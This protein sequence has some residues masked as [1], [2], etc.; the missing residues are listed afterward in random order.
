MTN[1]PH[2][3]MPP[4]LPSRT[5]LLVSLGINIFLVAFIL[6]RLTGPVMP[7]PPMPFGGADMPSV[8]AAA[9][10][11]GDE[12]PCHSKKAFY[13]KKDG[14]L[15][16]LFSEAE[17]NTHSEAARTKFDQIKKAKQDFAARL[18]EGPVSEEEAMAFFTAMGGHF[19]RMKA[20]M[21]VKAAAKVA[22]MDDSQRAAFAARLKRDDRPRD[23]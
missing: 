10:P 23:R 2:A 15:S 21:H 12:E 19:E 22:A 14:V 3:P 6:G 4:R 9:P 5:A 20:E 18:T 13:G 8:T 16:G 11:A 1:Q 17:M 7:M